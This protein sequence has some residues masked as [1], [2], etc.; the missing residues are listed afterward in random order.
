MSKIFQVKA[1]KRYWSLLCFRGIF[2]VNCIDLYDRTE[3]KQRKKKLR[4][5]LSNSLEVNNAECSEILRKTPRLLNCYRLN[6]YILQIL[7]RIR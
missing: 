5:A 4:K 3:H 6:N 7:L 2:V 1:G